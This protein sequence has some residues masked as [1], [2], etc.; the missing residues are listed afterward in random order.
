M[1]LRLEMDQDPSLTIYKCDGK[2]TVT[3]TTPHKTI[4]TMNNNDNKSIITLHYDKLD[5]SL[6][7]IFVIIP[8]PYHYHF[9]NHPDHWLPVLCALVGQCVKS[10]ELII[11][12]LLSSFRHKMDLLITEKVSPKHHDQRIPV[13]RGLGVSRLALIIWSQ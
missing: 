9:Y 12:S 13:L 10:K 3:L 11:W 6:S 8:G 1:R 2:T 4:C 7:Q 5:Q